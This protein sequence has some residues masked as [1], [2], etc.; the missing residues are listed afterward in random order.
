MTLRRR[1]RRKV[2]V[3]RISVAELEMGYSTDRPTALTI[4]PHLAISLSK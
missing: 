1:R 4:V 3:S 2:A